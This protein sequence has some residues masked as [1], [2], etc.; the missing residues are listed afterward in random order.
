VHVGATAQRETSAAPSA[1][2]ASSSAAIPTT[3]AESTSSTNAGATRV[4]PSA[5]PPEQ[6]IH[7]SQCAQPLEGA[8]GFARTR[9]EVQGVPTQSAIVPA[10]VQGLG[11]RVWRF[12]GAGFMPWREVWVWGVWYRVKGFRVQGLGLRPAKGRASLLASGS[13]VQGVEVRAQGLP[14]TRAP[15]WCLRP[16]TFPRSFPLLHYS[17]VSWYNSGNVLTARLQFPHVPVARAPTE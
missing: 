7:A 12:E 13:R 4:P 16:A 1:G 6:G 10:R 14:V 15:E 8:D 17:P 5:R 2:Q 9:W 11:I 3:H